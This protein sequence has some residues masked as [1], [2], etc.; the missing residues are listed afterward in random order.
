MTDTTGATNSHMSVSDVVRAYDT[1]HGKVYRM[2]RD[3]V[4]APQY[5]T[6]QK[7][8]GRRGWRHLIAADAVLALNLPSRVV[9]P[10]QAVETHTSVAGAVGFPSIATGTP[11]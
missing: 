7:Y 3:G 9:V 10:P 1:T 6:Q 11:T 8:K 5:I 2:I 4:I